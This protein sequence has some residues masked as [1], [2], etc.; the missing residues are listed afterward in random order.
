VYHPSTIEKNITISERVMAP[1]RY[2]LGWVAMTS[3][4]ADFASWFARGPLLTDGAWG[5]ELQ[6]RGLAPGACPDA[7]NRDRAD[8]VAAVAEAYV[9]AGAGAILTNTFGANRVVLANHG[10]A[11][12]AAALSRAGAMISRAAAGTRAKVIASS[13]PSGK[14]LATEDISRE[15]LYAC[16]AEQAQALA[17]GGAD[18][19]LCETFAELAEAEIA[20]RAAVATGLPVIASMT[21]SAGKALDR[22]PFG[23][24]PEQAAAALAA[25]GASAIG[26]NCGLGSDQLLPLIPRLRAAG[27]P[28]WIKPNAGAPTLVNGEVFYPT[29]PANFAAAARI[30]ASSGAAFVGGCC[31]TGPAHILA[32]AAA[33]FQS[34][35][36]KA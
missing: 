23:T 20:V 21:Y 34:A 7:W 29:S 10:L 30:L 15:E 32:L 5:T 13:G 4:A 31:G 8:A 9:A 24:T 11:E 35:R 22:T 14:V 36:A 26:A 19:L 2:Q 6:A 25:A 18:A 1:G 17:E 12:Q 27:L 28:V 33:G 16:F 3:T